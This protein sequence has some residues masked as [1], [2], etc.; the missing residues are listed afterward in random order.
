VG[1]PTAFL[2]RD[3][4]VN[5]KA[6]E[7]DYITAPDQVRLLPAAAAAV[8]RL[9]D[10]DALVV[11]VTNQRG[12]ALG[13]MT[14][15]DLAGVHRRLQELLDEQAGAHVDAFFACPHDHGE[16][17]CRKPQP[18]LLQAALSAFPDIDVGRS[19]LIGDAP[20]D[21]A[22]GE[23]AGVAALQIGRDAPDL[24]VAVARAVEAG[25]LVTG[26][27]ARGGTGAHTRVGMSAPARVATDEP[28]RA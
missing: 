12:I 8:R 16:C 10:L 1:R 22:A 15:D 6:P 13:R 17:D 26:A 3:G 11:I 21:V 28:A 18:G 9:N 5:V 2:D 14:G 25:L 24:N 23:R 20:S 4:T 7:G 19:V 27:P